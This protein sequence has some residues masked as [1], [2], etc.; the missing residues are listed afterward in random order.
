MSVLS[1]HNLQE[2]FVGTNI[3]RTASPQVSNSSATGYI[4]N[5]EIVVVNSSGVVYDASSMSY[6]T[7]PWIQIVQR[8]GDQLVWSSKIEGHKLKSYRGVAAGQGQEQIY[9][10]GYNGTTGSLDTT[11]GLDYRITLIENQDDMNKKRNLLLMYH[12]H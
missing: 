2:T 6:A 10:V 4:A 7:S 8:S 9:T 11:S 12:L 5:G 3:S 1:V